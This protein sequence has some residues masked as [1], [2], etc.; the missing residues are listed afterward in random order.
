M[1][2]VSKLDVFNETTPAKSG[3]AVW[4]D[5]TGNFEGGNNV[6]IGGVPN[7]ELAIERVTTSDKKSIIMRKCKM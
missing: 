3:D 4:E 5:L 7:E 6:T 1:R 2:S